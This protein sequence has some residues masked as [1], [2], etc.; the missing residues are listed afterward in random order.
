MPDEKVALKQLN[1]VTIYVLPDGRFE[2]SIKTWRIARKDLR[3]VEKEVAARTTAGEPVRLRVW[4]ETGSRV[5]LTE[6][7]VTAARGVARY[8]AREF[9]TDDGRLITINAPHTQGG[10]LRHAYFRDDPALADELDALED[11]HGAAIAAARAA[12]QADLDA[13][14]GRLVGVGPDDVAR[15]LEAGKEKKDAGD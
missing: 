8:G 15:L 11:R 10:L 9:A 4:R 7:T 13:L 1:G 14:R 2:A 3:A 6:V 5:W 12:R